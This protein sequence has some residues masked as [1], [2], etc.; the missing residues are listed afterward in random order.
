MKKSIAYLFILLLVGSCNKKKQFSGPNFYQDNFEAYH[1]LE[2]LLV[3]NDTFFSFTQQ[4]ITQ[5]TIT[6]DTTF[7]HTGKKSLRFDAV[8]S[9]DNL[10][11]C[12]IAKQNMAFW[13]GETAQLTAWYYIQGDAP[14]QWLFLFDFEEQVPIGAGPGIRLA[15]VDNK[16]R[17][18]Y[19]FFEKDIVQTPGSEIDFPRNQWVQLVWQIKLHQKDKGSVRLWQD[20]KLILSKDD[21]ATLPKDILYAQQGTKKMYTSVEIGA[22][23]NTRDSDITLWVDDVKFEK[24]N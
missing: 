12:S 19:K 10:S 3:P 24:I 20:G 16:L 6:V 21:V 4:T 14:A 1:T 9:S 7:Y 8:Q 22:T 17:M 15:L 18:E 2:D 13:Q 5:N 11:K 23:A